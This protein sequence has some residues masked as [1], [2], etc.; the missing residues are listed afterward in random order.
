MTDKE[1]EQTIIVPFDREDVVE[2]S[3][4]GG[5]DAIVVRLD[6]NKARVLISAMELM[7]SFQRMAETMMDDS[8]C[9]VGSMRMN[10]TGVLL[11]KG[12]SESFKKKLFVSG[13]KALAT[14]HHSII[15]K[16]VAKWE[17]HTPEDAEVFVGPHCVDVKVEPSPF[18]DAVFGERVTQDV[19]KLLA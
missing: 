4:L 9:Y 1:I 2:E 13:P 11:V 15:D 7:R 14:I 6:R 10:V 5:F 8:D 16:E 19:L 12:L 3:K 17:L 18:T